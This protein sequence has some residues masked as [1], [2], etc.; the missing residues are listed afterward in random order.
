MAK[1]ACRAKKEGKV[2]TRG[3]TTIEWY[4]KGV[5]QYYCYGY[6]DKMTDELL[7]VCQNCVDY[8]GHAQE[9]L[10]KWNKHRKFSGK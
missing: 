9:E 10:E 6:I 8:V 3:K 5:P 4:K 7:E 2:P 1:T